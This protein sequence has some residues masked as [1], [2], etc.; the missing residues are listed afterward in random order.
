MKLPE[1][2]NEIMEDDDLSG[3]EFGLDDPELNGESEDSD[4][5]ADNDE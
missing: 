1:I 3:E 2:K 4:E 5:E